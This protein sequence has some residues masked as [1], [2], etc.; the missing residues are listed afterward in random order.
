[1][2]TFVAQRDSG[3]HRFNISQWLGTVTAIGLN[4]AYHP[5]NERGLSPALRTVGYALASGMGLVAGHDR[6]ES[7]D[8]I[9][10]VILG[11]T[12]PRKPAPLEM[13]STGVT[14][15]AQCQRRNAV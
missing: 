14:R 15:G 5:G 4:D 13:Y 12:Q 3:K 9:S 6:G 10:S 1:M 2:H 11:L 7:H 8:R